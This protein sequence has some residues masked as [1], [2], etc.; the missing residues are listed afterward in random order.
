[1]S[2]II[3]IYTDGS[4]NPSANRG[5]WAAIIF[6]G[7]EKKIMNGYETDTTHQRMELTAVIKALEF[8]KVNNLLSAPVQVYTDSQYLV[9]LPERKEKLEA[10]DYRTRKNRALPNTDLI[11]QVIG[12]CALW[13]ITFI[14]VKAHQKLT[15]DENYNRE[16][17]MLS[18]KIVRGFEK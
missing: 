3:S 11:R 17:D 10:S 1:M 2:D 5:G 4:C 18:R 16:A 13:P 8:L 9:R 15:G 14:K 12:Y 6:M 7:E